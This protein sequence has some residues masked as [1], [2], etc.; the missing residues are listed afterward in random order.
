MITLAIIYLIVA[1]NVLLVLVLSQ[2]EIA[3]K[4]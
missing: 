3:G 2:Y 4:S 1:A